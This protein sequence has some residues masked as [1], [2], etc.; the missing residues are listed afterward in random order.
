VSSYDEEVQISAL[1]A[2]SE[3]NKLAV[4]KSHARNAEWVNIS[5]LKRK[6]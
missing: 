3:D 6:D 4:G 1:M 5:M 2:L